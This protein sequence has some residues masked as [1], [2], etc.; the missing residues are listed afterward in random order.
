MELGEPVVLML[1]ERAKQ[2]P[3]KALS[4][5]A[6]HRGGSVRS[7]VEVSVMEMERRADMSK[8]N[9]RSTKWEEP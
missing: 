6:A 1:R 5:N 8:I 2:K 7:S 3:C 9:Y 4:T